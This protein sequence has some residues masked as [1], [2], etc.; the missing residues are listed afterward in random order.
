M[1]FIYFFYDGLNFPFI[2]L[3]QIFPVSCV[4]V[5]DTKFHRFF[6]S[7]PQVKCVV[8][9]NKKPN[10]IF[11]VI[12]VWRK[13]LNLYCFHKSMM[14]NEKQH[15]KVRQIKWKKLV[16]LFVHSVFAVCFKSRFKVLKNMVLNS[17]KSF[18]QKKKKK[19]T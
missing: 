9:W 1:F 12:F 4:C 2:L 7:S 10:I 19:N 18:L 14:S 3:C 17:N 5:C 16:I 8:E 15:L 11:F 6:F 13:I